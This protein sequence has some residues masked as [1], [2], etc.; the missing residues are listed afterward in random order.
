VIIDPEDGLTTKD[1]LIVVYGLAA[2]GSTITRDIPLWFD[3]HTVADAS[4]LW[5]FTLPLNI[6]ENAFT[7]RV[8]D[9]V[10][11]AQTLTVHCVA[12]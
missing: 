8:G 2:P 3:E 7:F 11:T 4:G 10:S 5:S 6:G 1:T 9:D 12:N